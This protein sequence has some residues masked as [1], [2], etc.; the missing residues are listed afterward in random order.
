MC[1]RTD[2]DLLV[3]RAGVTEE[4]RQ[5]ERFFRERIDGRLADAEKKDSADPTRGGAAEI[6]ICRHCD[7]LVRR[8]EN[9]TPWQDDVYAPFAMERMLHAHIRAFRR[10]AARYRSLLGRGARVVEVGSYVGG[11]L[12]VAREWGWDAV[13][14]DVGRD[15]S[16][17]AR[18]HAYLTREQPLEKCGFKSRSF[19]GVFIWNCFEQIAD[20]KSLL[21]EVRRI[22]KPGGALVVRVPNARFYRSTRDIKLLGYSNLL[23]FPHLYGFTVQSLNSLLHQCGFEP[24]DWWTS[25]HIDPGIRPLTATARKEAAQLAP[26][27]RRSWIEV[28]SLLPGENVPRSGG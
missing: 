26:K 9:A 24:V 1:G 14:V 3:P 23:G 27:L 17:F 19:D 15:T 11:F 6:L 7:I 20:P 13:G 4:L 2:L 16:R 22:L 8:D 10:K 18:A 28:T 21:A 12:H 5:R 25:P